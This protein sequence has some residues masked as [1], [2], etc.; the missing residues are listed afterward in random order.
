MNVI[1]YEFAVAA[2]EE[3]DIAKTQTSIATD[4]LEDELAGILNVRMDELIVEHD[5][6][7]L[8]IQDLQALHGNEIEGL[9]RVTIT[10][11]YMEGAKYSGKVVGEDNIFP[12][13]TNIAKIEQLTQGTLLFFWRQLDLQIK[14]NEA[15]AMARSQLTDE[16]FATYRKANPLLG[17]YGVAPAAGL[18]ANEAVTFSVAQGT[19]DKLGELKR[20]KVETGQRHWK[21]V[22]VSRLDEITCIICHALD[23]RRSHVE[24]EVGSPFIIWPQYNTHKRCRCRLMIK[25]GEK[26]YTLF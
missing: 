19:V 15:K 5:K 16:Q 17:W 6:K 24:Y 23:Y 4:A 3:L 26:L 13:G 7:N 25:E 8:Q 21:I 22:F 1:E 14:S 10:N 12:T 2:M 20:A 9:I 11:A 18:I